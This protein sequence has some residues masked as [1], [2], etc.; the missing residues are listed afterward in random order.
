[1]TS[2]FLENVQRYLL[3]KAVARYGMMY[4]DNSSKIGTC[5]QNK[6]YHKKSDVE[7]LK[8]IFFYLMD[9]YNTLR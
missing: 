4:L 9:Y 3:S 2:N 8:N 5:F 7:N 6:L 1:M